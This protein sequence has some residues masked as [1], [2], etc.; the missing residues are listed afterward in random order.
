VFTGEDAQMIA[1]ALFGDLSFFKPAP[2]LGDIKSIFSK[3]EMISAK[4]SWG[5]YTKKEALIKM[6]PCLV[7]Q[8]SRMYHLHL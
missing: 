3:E 4:Q 7:D 8:S 1:N 6:I 5:A 2:T